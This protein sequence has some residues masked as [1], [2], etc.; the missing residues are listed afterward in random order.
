M[1]TQTEN[2]VQS[3]QAL[4]AIERLVQFAAHKKMIA[5]EDVNY[6]RNVLLDL[7]QFHAPYIGEWSADEVPADEPHALLAQL[8]N[9]GFT[10]GLMPE[11][12]TTYADL[13]DAKIM[14]LLMPRPSEVVR[15]FRDTAKDQGVED[16]TKDFYNLC[17]DS[18]YIQMERIRKNS[19]WRH[20][21]DYGDIEMTINLSKPEKN[22][23]EIAMALKAAPSHYPKCLL[24]AENVGYAG[25]LNHPARQN[26]RVIPVELTQEPWFFQYSPYVY[27]NEHCIVFHSEHVPMKLTHETFARLVDFVDQFPHY[28]VGTNADLP[29][30]GGSI[31]THDH[32]QGGRHTF[33]I[34]LSSLETRFSHDVHPAVQIHRVKWP[35]SVLRL[36]SKKREAL[37]GAANEVYDAWK[38]YSD[39]DANVIA[40]SERDGQLVPHN[41]VTPIVR[42]NVKG[43]YEMDLVLRNNRTDADH[44]EGIYHPHRHLHHIKKENIGLIEVMGVAIL[45]GRLKSQ[46]EQIALILSG[47]LPWTHERAEDRYAS[48]AEHIPWVEQLRATHGQLS[49]K[50]EAMRIV[51]QEV[52]D[53]FV[54]IL[55]CAGVYKRTE[56]GIAAFNRFVHSMG[57]KETTE[58]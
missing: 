16:A 14:G 15:N 55:S 22:P 21:S 23:Q 2:H 18:N 5:A 53:K 54:E 49:S 9:Y 25:R 6:A 45:P 51:E 43:E 34:E 26:L 56:Q 37:L 20:P 12:N 27:Y 52:G 38:S 24:C 17:I 3:E 39:E 58:V 57:W 50:D 1:M 32:F 42:Y 10:I 13:L 33:P 48:I 35:M 4:V 11:L 47:E 29:I 36:T 28:F 7:F 40:Y 41:T 8:I 30:V 31:L 44:P 46:L 19:Y